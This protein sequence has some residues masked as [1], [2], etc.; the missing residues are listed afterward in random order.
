MPRRGSRQSKV[1]RN[2]KEKICL[3]HVFRQAISWY[4]GCSAPYRTQ[5]TDAWQGKQIVVSRRRATIA[6]RHSSVGAFKWPGCGAGQRTHDERS[7]RI[8]ARGIGKQGRIGVAHH[9][10]R[11]ITKVGR[12]FLTSASSTI[13]MRRLSSV[14]QRPSSRA[15]ATAWSS[16]RMVSR[17]SRSADRRARCR[18]GATLRISQSHNPRNRRRHGSSVASGEVQTSIWPYCARSLIGR[19]ARLMARLISPRRARPSREPGGVDDGEEFQRG[20]RHAAVTVAFAERKLHHF[21]VEPALHAQPFVAQ[22]AA[23]EGE[24]RQA[25]TARPIA[26][27]GFRRARTAQRF[28]RAGRPGPNQA[29]PHARMTARHARE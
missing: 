3:A 24:M 15:A 6:R 4:T 19:M 10:V 22:S 27:I 12:K 29:R 20:R 1:E 17:R 5:V 26:S 23:G 8:I 14:S 2:A 7:H 25:R 11:P 16:P 13:A 18:R 9:A 21:I 28:R